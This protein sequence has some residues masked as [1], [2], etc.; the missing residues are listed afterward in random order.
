MNLIERM[1]GQDWVR[2]LL[3]Q[4][5]LKFGT[6]GASGMFVNLGIFYLA[7]EYLFS[8][9]ESPHLRLNIALAMAILCAT[10]NNYYWNRLWTWRDRRQNHQHR[11]W[12]LQFCQ[13]AMACWIGI[14]LQVAFT[15]LL[16][17]YFHYLI[18]NMIAIVMASLFNFLLNDLWTFRHHKIPATKAGD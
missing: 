5:F 2:W 4:R 6:V 14:A 7:Q 9:I 8:F 1:H 18:A 15:N 3:H 13:Y 12:L 11:T 10:V 17:S 16:V